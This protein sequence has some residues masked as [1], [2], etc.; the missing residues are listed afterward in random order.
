[1]ARIVLFQHHPGT[2]LLHRLDPRIKLLLLLSITSVAAAAG[3]LGLIVAAGAVA[4]GLVVMCIPLLDLLRGL[5]GLLLM[6]LLIVLARTLSAD[7]RLLG[8][9]DGGLLSARL[10]LMALLG[11]VYV[12]ATP[13]SHTKA[14]VTWFLSPIPLLPAARIGI[15]MGLALASI[16]LFLD[17]YA[18][19]TAAVEAR[20]IGYSR[21]PLRRALF[22]LRPFLGKAFRRADE[23]ALAMEARCFTDKA[24]ITLYPLK[25]QDWIALSVAA[26]V[27]V[28]SVVGRLRG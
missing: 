11:S 23:M 9:R 22:T 2:T 27:A 6:C 25:A 3:G 21:N 15:M 4:G 12:A 26:V 5:R 14:A 8:L 1:M 10:I 18:E 17:Q 28:L 20:C 16:S 7:V 13:L 24:T 19:T